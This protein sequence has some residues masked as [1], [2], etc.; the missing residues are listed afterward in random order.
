MQ[1]RNNFLWKIVKGTRAVG[2]WGWLQAV[3]LIER[4][5]DGGVGDEMVNVVVG[6]SE[7]L[8]F[9]RKGR[10]ARKGIVDVAD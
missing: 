2:D 7:A 9:V 5:S 4:A 3:E 10:G 8:G 6:G 1:Y